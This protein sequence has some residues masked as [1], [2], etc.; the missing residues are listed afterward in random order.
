MLRLNLTWAAA[1]P[2]TESLKISARLV[3][4]QGTCVAQTDQIPVHFTYPTTMWVPGER[5]QD[6]YDLA[7]PGSSDPTDSSRVP[8]ELKAQQVLLIL[9]RAADGHE[10][11]RLVLPAALATAG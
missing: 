11:G 4:Q 2:V 5:V 3:D 10:V 7:L 9:Y 6:V 8:A 1:A